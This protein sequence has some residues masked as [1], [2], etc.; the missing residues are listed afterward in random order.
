MEVPAVL[1]EGTGRQ[2]GIHISSE[3]APRGARGVLLK[4]EGLGAERGAKRR[5]EAPARG[6]SSLIQNSNEGGCLPCP[7][8]RGWL[9]LALEKP[10]SPG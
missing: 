4:P 9:D 10:R 6:W 7:G 2:K 5:Q 1:K 3:T 8:E